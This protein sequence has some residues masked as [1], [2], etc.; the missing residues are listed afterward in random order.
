VNVP[1]SWEL[2]AELTYQVVRRWKGEQPRFAF[3]PKG[4]VL[5]ADLRDVVG[6]PFARNQSAREL[7]EHVIKRCIEET[8]ES[9]TVLMLEIVL[10]RAGIPI[11]RVSL[12][13]LGLK[14]GTA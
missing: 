14:V 12:S 6:R 7:L 10:E 11:E 9:P 4:V 1:P 3:P 5:V 2:G 8:G 13:E